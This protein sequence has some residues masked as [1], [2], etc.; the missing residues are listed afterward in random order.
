MRSSR[1][2]FTLIV[3]LCGVVVMALSQV[4]AARG[5]EKALCDFLLELGIV[6]SV[7]FCGHSAVEGLFRT[8]AEDHLTQL[9]DDVVAQCLATSRNGLTLISDHRKHLPA[10]YTWL[11]SAKPRPICIGGRSCLHRIEEDWLDRFKKKDELDKVIARRVHQGCRIRILFHDPRSG[12]V[13]SMAT[14]EIRKPHEIY[15]DLARSL[16]VCK[17]IADQLERQ[18]NQKKHL[19]DNAGLTISIS[20][21]IPHFSFHGNN[22]TAIIGFYFPREQGSQSGAWQAGTAEAVRIFYDGFIQAFRGATVLLAADPEHNE[23]RF[24]D[25]LYNELRELLKTKATPGA[26]STW[27]PEVELDCQRP[28]TD[29]SDPCLPHEE[30]AT[31]SRYRNNTPDSDPNTPSQAQDPDKQS[32]P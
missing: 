2:W 7:V 20:P 19:P 6:V 21:A 26:V 8:E 16:G 30:H 17:R 15:A 14:D 5:Y 12:L 23:I 31:P 22:E 10:Y 28:A 27:M 18:R 25:N 29:S 11:R 32:R 13:E 24:D 3:A 4:L 9:L 1:L